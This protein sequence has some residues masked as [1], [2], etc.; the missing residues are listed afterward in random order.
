MQIPRNQRVP[1]FAAAIGVTVRDIVALNGEVEATPISLR[2][3]QRDAHD[4]LTGV[5]TMYDLRRY[6]FTRG[7]TRGL[8]AAPRVQRPRLLLALG[9]FEAIC[10]AAAEEHRSDTIY[11]APP[12]QWVQ[13]ATD[14]LVALID[15]GNVVRVVISMP[16][17]V[18]GQQMAASAVEIVTRR[19]P[20]RVSVKVS[21][22]EAGSWSQALRLLRA[23]RAA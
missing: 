20:G 17:S 14:A 11:A 2:S 5:E 12:G 6:S 9:P 23:R 10:A 3:M 15:G 22:P 13:R 7:G 8:F 1:A 21:P 16:T 4:A 18:Q 19:F